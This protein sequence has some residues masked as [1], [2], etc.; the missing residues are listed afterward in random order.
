LPILISAIRICVEGGGLTSQVCAIRQ[1]LS[2]SLVPYNQKYAV[3]QEQEIKDILVQ[4]DRFL[5]VADPRGNEPKK[6]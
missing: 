6:S 5:L 3:E 2:K 1:A 4:F